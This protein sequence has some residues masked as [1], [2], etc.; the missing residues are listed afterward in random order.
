MATCE[1]CGNDYWLAFEVRTVSGDVHTFDSFECASHK[2]APIC[3]H[4]GVKIL[5]H[6]VEV[7]G[8][9]FCCGHCARAVETEQGAEIRDAVGARPA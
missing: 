6:G 4:C 3:E 5:G 2:L 1:V 7:S 9:F 8:R